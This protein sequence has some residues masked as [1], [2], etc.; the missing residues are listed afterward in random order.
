[1][2]PARTPRTPAHLSPAAGRWWRDV[3]LTYALES[4]HIRL[5]TLAAENW[6]TAEKARAA[7]AEHGL[8]F[9]DHLGQPRAR[10]ENAIARNAAIVFARLVRELALDVEPEAPRPPVIGGRERRT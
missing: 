5:L 9:T 3:L 4:H 6:D 8:V 1:M 10:P 2:T 7:L